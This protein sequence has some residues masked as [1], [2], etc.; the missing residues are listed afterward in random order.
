[1]KCLII[2]GGRG[3]RLQHKSSSKLFV[4]VLGRPT[5]ERAIRTG[6]GAGIDAFCVARGYAGEAVLRFLDGLKE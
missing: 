1:M 3:S 5:I 6:V 4:P 2:A